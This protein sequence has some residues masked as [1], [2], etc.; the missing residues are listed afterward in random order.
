MASQRRCDFS[1]AKRNGRRGD[2]S[3]GDLVTKSS[4]TT[5]GCQVFMGPDSELTGLRQVEEGCVSLMAGGRRRALVAPTASRYF[6][7]SSWT[8]TCT[9]LRMQN[10]A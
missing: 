2:A 9:G 8:L 10:Q 7:R 5:P 3:C 6:L 4:N 1:K